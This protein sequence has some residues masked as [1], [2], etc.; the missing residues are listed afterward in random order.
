M[1]DLDI[2]GCCTHWVQALLS[3]RISYVK[4]YGTNSNKKRFDH[5]V[6]QGSVIAPLLWLIYINDLVSSMPIE[7]QIGVSSSLFA[8]DLAFICKGKSIKECE[9]KMQPAL[10]SLEDWAKRNKMQISIRGD[11]K[12][13]TVSCF[14]TKNY[15]SESKN[16]VT[17]QLTLNGINIY[18]STTPKFLGVTIDQDLSF[19]D[20]TDEKAK[21]MGKRNNILR[22]LSGRSWGQKSTTLRSVY[23]TYT[24]PAAEYAAGAWAPF[25][26]KSHLN[27][28]EVKQNEAARIITGCCKDTV[29]EHLLCEAGLMPITTR[30]EQE[31]ALLYEKNLRLPKD[32]PARQTAEAKVKKHRLKKKAADGEP[33]KPPREKAIS[34]LKEMEMYDIKREESLTHSSMEPWN[35]RYSNITFK[36][37]LDGCSGKKD[38]KENVLDAFKTQL[39]SVGESDTV[40]YTDGSVGENNKNGALVA[41]STGQLQPMRNPQSSRYHVGECAPPTDPR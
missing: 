20:H 30:A 14:Y 38:S 17:P 18:H 24:L 28:L 41:S 26:A 6:P 23:S 40:I 15:R 9:E 8:D 33:I 12:S 25:T 5:G 11:D 29:R 34:I 16:K 36:S 19:K 27:K 31:T 4:W 7:V 35:W 22:A 37:D 32:V 21:M 2:P 13:K 1:G 39:K 3:D 10:D